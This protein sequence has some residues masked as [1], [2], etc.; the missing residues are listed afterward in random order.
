MDSD[1]PSSRQLM[2]T[3]VSASSGSY[4]SAEMLTSTILVYLERHRPID[5]LPDRESATLSTWLTAH[6]GIEIVSRDRSQ[7]Y[8]A[9]ITE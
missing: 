3:S 9:G 5:L 2:V 4:S 8:A 1:S 7:A 6:P